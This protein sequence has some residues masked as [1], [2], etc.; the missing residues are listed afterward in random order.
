[1]CCYK[2]KHEL[3]IILQELTLAKK[4]IQILQ[5]D[6]NAKPNHGILSTK[7]ANQIMT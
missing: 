2:L 4:I 7:E 1:V 6:V 5:E 3:E